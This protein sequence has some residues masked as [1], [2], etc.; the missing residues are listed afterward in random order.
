MLPILDVITV[1]GGLIVPPAYD[2]IKKKFVKEENDTPERTIGALATTN[3]ETVPAY[4]ESLCKFF[5]AQGRYFNRDVIGEVSLWI[6]NF[7]A[8]I[9]PIAVVSSLCILGIMA[10]SV[11]FYSYTPPTKE[12][13]ELLMG[14]RISCEGISSSW[15]GSRLA[16][17]N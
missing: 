14:I 4:V 3:P 2:F 9:R 5:D 10:I 6:R 17:K 11:L 15:M 13:S 7:R 1:L 16:L 8:S 12:A